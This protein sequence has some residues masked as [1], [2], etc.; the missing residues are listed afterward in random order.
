[1]SIL[2]KDIWTLISDYLCYV[3][4]YALKLVCKKSSKIKLDFKKI[5][6]DKLSIIIDNTEEFL[7]KILESG[8]IISGSFILAC[9]Y[10]IDDF[11]D[12]DIFD[13]TEN[14][15]DC[16]TEISKYLYQKYK[17]DN[18]TYK[19]VFC[20]RDFHTKYKKIQHIMVPL[21]PINYIN[22]TFDMEI[23]KN[24]FDGEKLYIKSWNKLINRSDYIK[25]NGLLMEYYVDTSK[26]KELSFNRL[27]KYKERG[28]NVQLHP[29]YDE[30]KT[31]I[32]EK[33]ITQT[34]HIRN[35]SCEY[36][37]SVI[38]NQIQDIYKCS[39]FSHHKCNYSI[40]IEDELISKLKI[41]HPSFIIPCPFFDPFPKQTR[42]NVIDLSIYD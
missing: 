27:K 3:D 22:A 10:D 16:F 32:E 40:M 36:F 25:P 28:F 41:K 7:I 21:N 12:V 5:L 35:C 34:D 26:V 2:T 4:K 15:S 38:F 19:F 1:M 23:C 11:N 39:C 9:L 31:F 30:I 14:Y 18:K 42:N 8:A 6:T 37:W 17:Y 13:P 33:M 24:F 20:V 29:K